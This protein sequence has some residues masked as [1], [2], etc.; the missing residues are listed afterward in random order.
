MTE[1]PASLVYVVDDDFSV[2]DSL[3]LFLNS[4]GLEVKSFES[5]NAFLAAYDPQHPACLV[6][7][8]RMPG[9]DGLGL[10][11]ELN[12][13]SISLPVIFIS[14]HAEVPD[15][16][17]AFRSGALDFL[18]KPFDNKTLLERIRE[19]LNK[20]VA[21]RRQQQKKRL[22][23]ERLNALTARE[24]DVLALILNN[25]SNKEAA[26]IL[27]ISHRTVDVHRAKIMEKMQ[28]ANLA[29]LIRMMMESQH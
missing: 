4:A 16:A 23:E 7:D 3:T 22:L 14:G 12:K 5:A 9:L 11:N 21:I 19:A 10:Q 24:N 25:H 15:S 26:R 6:L 13:E 27:G 29:E 17:R 2:R 28:A 8:I 1:H 20:D 18:E